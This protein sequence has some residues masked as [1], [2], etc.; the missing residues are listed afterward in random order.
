MHCPGCFTAGKETPC[1]LCR[2]LGRQVWKT[3]PPHGFNPQT[4]QPVFSHYIDYAILAHG[5]WQGEEIKSFRIW[6]VKAQTGTV[7]KGYYSP[8][9]YT[10]FCLLIS[11]L[12][13]TRNKL[14]LTLK[15]SPF[16][17]EHP[18]TETG[19]EPHCNSLTL[20]YHI[21]EA[22][23]QVEASPS[24]SQ[25]T[26][27]D[28]DSHD[29]RELYE[30]TTLLSTTWHFY[31]LNIQT[32]SCLHMSIFPMLIPHAIP[33]LEC[34][35]DVRLIFRVWKAVGIWSSANTTCSKMVIFSLDIHSDWFSYCMCN[36]RNSAWRQS[37]QKL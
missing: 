29:C 11:T 2:R 15:Y 27:P 28:L 20:V 22:W 17:W 34:L 13:A 9:A 1:S 19:L 16:H 35:T 14:I 21:H 10:I 23:S 36:E 7:R 24:N 3:S 33:S 12:C 30:S 32:V 25:Q 31:I 26:I 5:R 37:G 8:E 18:V 6:K 4:V